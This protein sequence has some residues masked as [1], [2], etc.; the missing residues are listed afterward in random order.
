MTANDS[1]YSLEAEQLVIGGL[2]SDATAWDRCGHLVNA[3][4]FCRHDHQ[5]LFT[6]IAGLA[7]E[8]KPTEPQ[9]VAERL[10]ESGQLEEAGG[11]SLIATI[12]RNTHSAANIAHYA[13][14]VSERAKY[15]R[16]LAAIQEAGQMVQDHDKP[17]SDRVQAACSHIQDAAEASAG[18]E[19]PLLHTYG[20]DWLAN[21]EEMFRSGRKMV[22]LPTGFRD[23]DEVTLGMPGGEL[24]V[25]AARPSMGKSAFGLNI[26]ANLANDGK[27][28]FIA[29]LEMPVSAVMNRFASSVGRVE[30][31]SVRAA[32]F[33]ETG[34]GLAAF[35]AKMRDWKLAVDDRPKLDV[36][37]LESLLRAHRRRHG[38]HLAMVDYLQLMD[39]GSDTNRNNAVSTCTR[40]LK[41]LAGTLG[42]PIL[43]LSQLNRDL[44][45]RAD[46]RPIMSDLRDSGSIEQDAHTLLFLYRDA[47]YNPQTQNPDITEVIIAKSRDSERGLIVP[48]T[49]QLN[50]MRFANHAREWN[51]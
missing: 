24:I 7:A 34:P 43:L 32:R 37:R 26:C 4:D 42:I 6:A 9:A 30:Y 12:Y 13:E 20:H 19:V 45:K 10:K 46:R 51:E 33:N 14:I 8:Q 27:S 25:L 47:V 28:I 17:L 49:T 3:A 5:V 11:Q 38:L 15:R 23:L 22:G 16:V 31:A 35:G 1:R 39:M 18:S 44:E 2:M 41:N 48:M 29:S 36:N 21:H 50:Q 40:D